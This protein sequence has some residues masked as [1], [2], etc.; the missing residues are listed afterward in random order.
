MLS[1]VQLFSNSMDSRLLCP[2]DFPGKNI[3]VGCWFLLKWNLP[4]PGIK[5]VSPALAGGF[6][7]TE[8]PGTA[9]I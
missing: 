1:H 4:E 5:L 3:G 7:T 6:F 8:S 2:C 9:K